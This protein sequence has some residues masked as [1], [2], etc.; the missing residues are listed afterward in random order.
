MIWGFFVLFF[1]FEEAEGK[2]DRK[3]HLLHLKCILEVLHLS[4]GETPA[5]QP[6]KNSGATCLLKIVSGLDR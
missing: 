2:F 5:M 1:L 4:L 3:T 6:H